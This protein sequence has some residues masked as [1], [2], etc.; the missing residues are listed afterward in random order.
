MVLFQYFKNVG[1]FRILCIGKPD[2]AQMVGIVVDIAVGCGPVDI[3]GPYIAF[4]SR[5][6]LKVSI[7]YTLFCT[8]ES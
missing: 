3:R 1:V 4:G 5:E 2:V 7:S 6:E 8:D